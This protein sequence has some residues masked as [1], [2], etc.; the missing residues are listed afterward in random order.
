MGELLPAKVWTVA[1]G[2]QPCPMSARVAATTPAI[3]PTILL[4]DL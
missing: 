2:R 1:I 3:V 4:Y